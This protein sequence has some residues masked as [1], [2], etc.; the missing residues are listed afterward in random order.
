[1]RK[2]AVYSPYLDTFG[3]GEKYMMTIAE[4]LV[5]EN[6]EVDVFLDSHLKS[7]GADYL[8]NELSKRFALNLDRVNFIK[9]PIGKGSTILQRSFF[10]LNYD[11]LFYLTDG[12]IFYPT[13]KRNILHIQSPLVGQPTKSI[14]GKLKLRGWDLIIYNSNFTKEHSEKNW[15][16]KSK[17]IYPPIDVNKIKPLEKKKYILSV[18]RFFG[19]LK[20]KKH[21]V[22]INAFR[23][24]YDNGK[25]KGW[26]LLLVGAASK[27]DGPYLDE[28]KRMSQRLP[29]KF[30]PN[31]T[32][33]DLVKLYGHSSIYWHAAGFEESAPTKMEHFGIATVEAMAG[34]C[35]PVVVNRGGQTEIIEDSKTGFLW[36]S[37]Q[38]LERFTILLTQDESLRN[39]LSRNALFA[40]KRFSKERF[41]AE[42]VKLLEDL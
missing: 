27:G 6:L 14:W 20:S 13:S 7:L 37:L 1:M 30:Y 12:S 19:Y 18:G 25:I 21:E 24:L 41:K 9:A 29:V 39:E 38:D 33:D 11:I 15:P 35:V 4:L 22:L 36:N 42:I 17:I 23:E 28:L 34:G 3:G 40:S 2:A 32:Y 5:G 26:E 31:I 8:K 16:N 10:L